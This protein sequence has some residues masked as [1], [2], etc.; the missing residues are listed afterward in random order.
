MCSIIKAVLF[1]HI[2]LIELQITDNMS[3]KTSHHDRFLQEGIENQHL[4]FNFPTVISFR[5]KKSDL[6][7]NSVYRMSLRS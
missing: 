6:L 1:L 7:A 4:C 3:P 2:N 5:F